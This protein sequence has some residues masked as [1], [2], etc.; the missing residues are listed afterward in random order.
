M[1]IRGMKLAACTCVLL[2]GCLWANEKSESLAGYGGNVLLDTDG[3]PS[4]GAIHGTIGYAGLDLDF[5][6]NERAVTRTGDLQQPTVPGELP[7]IG[8]RNHATALGVGI[9]LKLSLFGIIASDHRFERYLDLGVDTG[10]GAGGA[11]AKA[12]HQAEG[13]SSA[14]YGAWAE[15]GT[16]R[17]GSGVVVIT[18]GIR[19]EVFSDPFY[20]QTQLAV[21]L[22]W[23]QREIPK[24]GMLRWR[25]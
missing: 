4:G 8:P 11:F 16:I 24:D 15:I 23:R 5:E 17:A 13:T 7:H 14:W 22:A 2:T 1:R 10:A 20:D 3:Q 18:S 25:D 9:D 21:G 12:P 19:R 6:A